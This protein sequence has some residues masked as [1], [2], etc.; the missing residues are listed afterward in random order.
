MRLFY[1]YR[2][3]AAYRTETAYTLETELRIETGECAAKIELCR[4][5]TPQLIEEIERILEALQVDG[6][7]GNNLKRELRVF[8]LE[9]RILLVLG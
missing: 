1:T 7:F 2:L 9:S 4:R 3:E 5:G 8:I 6:A